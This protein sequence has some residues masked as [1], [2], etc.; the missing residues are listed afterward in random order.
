MTAANSPGDRSAGFDLVESVDN[1]LNTVP[2]VMLGSEEDTFSVITDL[3]P[4][5]DALKTTALRR[6]RCIG[7]RWQA[8]QAGPAESNW[9]RSQSLMMM[10]TPSLTRMIELVDGGGVSVP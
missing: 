7:I 6:S 10:A 2:V 3:V 5:Q 9:S 8:P 4:L 1:P